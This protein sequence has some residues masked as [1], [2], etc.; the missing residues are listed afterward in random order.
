M[1]SKSTDGSRSPT[2]EVEL[3]EVDEDWVQ[4][5]IKNSKEFEGYGADVELIEVGEEWVD[6]NIEDSD[7]IYACGTEVDLM[8]IENQDFLLKN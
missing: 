1:A 6:E 4:S 8:E 2:N 5:N 7:N 3:I